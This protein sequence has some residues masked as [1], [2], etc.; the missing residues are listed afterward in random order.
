M[1]MVQFIKAVAA[2]RPYIAQKC[3]EKTADKV[4]SFTT[5]F[6]NYFYS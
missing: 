3:F 5:D 4:F 2:I 6:D 1:Q